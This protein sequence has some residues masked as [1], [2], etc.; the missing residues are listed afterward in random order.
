[1]SAKTIYDKLMNVF[2][3]SFGVCGLMGNLYAESALRSNNLQDSFQTKLGFTDESYT[4][5]VDNGSYTNFVKDSAGYGLAQWTYWS[6]KQNLLNYAKKVNKSIGDENMQVDFLISELKGYTTVFNTIKN[7]KSVKEASDVMLTQYERPANQSESVKNKRAEYGQ[8]YYDEFC[9]KV[10]EETKMSYSRQKVVDLVKSWEGKKESDGS[11]KTII[12]IYNAS[13]PFPRSTKMQYGWAWCACTWSALAKKLGYTAIMPIEISCYYI[14]E[15]AK[16]MGCWQ[17]NDAYVPKEG[18]A[19]IYDWEDNGVG[20]NK[21]NPDHI[22]T[23]IEVHKSAGYMVVM[24]GNYSNA[25]KRRTISLNGKYIRGFIT[26]KYTDNTV[27]A[28][29]Q[30]GGKNVDTVAREVIAGTWGTGTARKNALEAKGY[31][32]DT[33]Q[34]RVNEILNGSASKP[35]TSTPTQSATKKV[36]ATCSAKNFNKSFAGSYKTTAD[37]YMRNDAGTNKKALVCIPKGTTVQCYGYYNVFNGVKW[38]YIQ[39]TI[40]GVQYTGFSHSGYLKRA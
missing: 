25:V 14:I 31:N 38:Y 19:V 8:K 36:T 30:T 11:Y 22:G 16:K 29:A 37:L 27:S 23:I 5:A 39:V 34:Q 40:K 6:R 3:N 15:Q 18:D 13:A 33:I 17:E 24:E 4:Q 32:Y 35:S 10:K 21:G 7:A 28:P 26:P 9:S 2:D 1:M 20:D 12:D